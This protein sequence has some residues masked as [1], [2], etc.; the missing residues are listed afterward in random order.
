MICT[1]I[2]NDNAT[3][4]LSLTDIQIDQ[5]FLQI[6]NQNPS[7]YFQLSLQW[8]NSWS[9]DIGAPTHSRSYVLVGSS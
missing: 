6:N 2:N 7:G 1:K 3:S 9:Y 4:M 8:D 5:Q